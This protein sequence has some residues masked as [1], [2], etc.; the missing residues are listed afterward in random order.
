M[1]DKFAYDRSDSYDTTPDELIQNTI[2]R[3]SSYLKN[4]FPDHLSFGNG[5]FTIQRGSSQIMI[6]VRPFTDDD[7]CVECLANVV[8]GAKISTELMRFLLRKNA[9]LHF[10]SFSLLFDDTIAFSHTVNGKN[11]DE[12]ELN[13]AVVS[14]AIISDYY[15]DII[16]EM[17]GGKRASDTEHF[18]PEDHYF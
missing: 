14:V 11:L 2:E 5:S 10:G 4:N 7:T 3:V 13:T 16:V 17:A 12:N 9:E 8:S 1:E 6:I 18:S 15:D